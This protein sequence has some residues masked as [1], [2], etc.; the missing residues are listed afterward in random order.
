[1]R[2]KT[3]HGED[4]CRL[5]RQKALDSAGIF[6]FEGERK[7][8]QVLLRL[9]ASKIKI[10]V[11]NYCIL[12]GEIII[13]ADA[14]CEKAESL[15][16]SLFAAT[17]R[18]HNMRKHHQGPCWKGR[19]QVSLI[20]K[21]QCLAAASLAVSMLP[22]AMEIVRHPAEWK[23]SG[24]HELTGMK[25]RYRIIDREKACVHSGFAD[26]QEFSRWYLSQIDSLVKNRTANLFPFDAMAV[27]DN[28]RIGEIAA[29]L[30]GKFREIRRCRIPQMP[31]AKAIFVSKKWGRS[32]TR[33][34]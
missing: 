26:M 28:Q 10:S 4:F 30:P 20:Q 7:N 12:P 13:L 11:L 31:E 23:C 2:K 21:K 19:A 6:R 18:N 16:R 3:G 24:L 9:A 17:S 22:V 27:G 34:I 5:M 8:A 14:S 1:M 33:T 29:R 32:I 15:S 25:D